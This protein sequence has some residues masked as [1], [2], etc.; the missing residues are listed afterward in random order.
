MIALFAALALPAAKSW[1]SLFLSMAGLCLLVMTLVFLVGGPQPDALAQDGRG[2]ARVT[3]SELV[4]KLRASLAV[5]GAWWLLFGVFTYKMGE[6]LAD[7]MFG[8]WLTR[9]HSIPKETVALWLGGWGMGASVIGSFVGGYFATRFRPVNA[10]LLAGV[11]RL[12]P[13]LAQWALAAGFIDVSRGSIVPITMAEHCFG[14][15]LTTTMFALM[16][17][18]VDRRIGATHYTLLA[19]VEVLGKSFPGLLSGVV[20]DA[21]GIPQTFAIAVLLS[22]AFLLV[23]RRMPTPPVRES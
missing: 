21:V 23:A 1:S 10:V 16:M 7:A 8:V 3:W 18:S 20:A 2:V 6:T 14:G 12:L 5:R 19:S 11:L 15:V 4:S 17:A 13:L 9:E 22:A